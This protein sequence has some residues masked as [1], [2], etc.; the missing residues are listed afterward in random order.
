MI[1]SALKRFCLMS[2]AMV[3]GAA[4]LLGAAPP[5]PAPGSGAGALLIASPSIGDPRFYHAVILMVRHND[6]GAFGI[7][8][9]DPI[10]TRSLASLITA[11]GGQADGVTGKVRIYAGGPV[12]PRLGFV[13]HS[14][15]YHKADTLNID[16]RLALTANPQILLDIGHKKGPR[17]SLIAFGYAGWSAG[18]LEGE[19]AR[20]DWFTAPEEPT[21]V[22]NHPRRT[23][24][25][26]AMARRTLSL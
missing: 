4:L 10:G 6:K 20:H 11:T 3:F 18:Q 26:A 22:F 13:I 7:V 24:W 19:I 14:R 8:I 12:Q 9:N 16:S 23:L 5:P 1:G 2:A 21:L 15:D 17:H 25:R